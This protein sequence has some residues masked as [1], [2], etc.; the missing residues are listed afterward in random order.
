MRSHEFIRENKEDR[1]RLSNQGFEFP[2]QGQ[3][4]YRQSH[5]GH[6]VV[7]I[8]DGRTGKIVNIGEFGNFDDHEPNQKWLRIVFNNPNMDDEEW[9]NLED[10][11]WSDEQ[12]SEDVGGRKNDGNGFC[13]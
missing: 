6:G 8:A 1:L 13:N 12:L 3:Y 9:D 5:I 7:E 10:M 2:Q 4:G 11:L